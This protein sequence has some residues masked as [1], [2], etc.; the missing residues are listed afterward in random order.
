M[1]ILIA[2]FVAVGLMVAGGWLLDA[3]PSKMTME[4]LN[5]RYPRQVG[6]GG[7]ST[8]EEIRKYKQQAEIRFWESIANQPHAY[9]VNQSASLG[10]IG[11]L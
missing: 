5:V 11:A 1:E 8:Q 3:R 10:R 7:H 6:F 4:Q 9:N 2:I